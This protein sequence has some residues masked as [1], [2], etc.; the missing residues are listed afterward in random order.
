[1]GLKKQMLGAQFAGLRMLSNA[2]EQMREKVN[3]ILLQRMTGLNEIPQQHDF[4][5]TQQRNK[6]PN[7]SGG[8]V[9]NWNIENQGKQTIIIL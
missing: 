6:A 1:M 5:R 9:I 8:R 3:K 7:L 4:S 2:T